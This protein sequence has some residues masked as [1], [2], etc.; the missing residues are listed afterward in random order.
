MYKRLLPIF[1]LLGLA[2]SGFLQSKAA[3]QTGKTIQLED[4]NSSFFWD[5]EELSF[6]DDWL[7]DEIDSLFSQK[8]F[9]GF[10]DLTQPESTLS[11]FNLIN[12]RQSSANQAT[13][14]FLGFS[15]R[16]QVDITTSLIGGIEGS[17]RSWLTERYTL[18]NHASEAEDLAFFYYQ[19]YDMG[20]ASSFNNDST[21]VDGNRVIQ[22]DGDQSNMTECGDSLS[23]FPQC[24][25]TD[26][27]VIVKSDQ[28][29]DSFEVDTYPQLLAKFFNESST[30]LDSEKD[31]LFDGDGTVAL[32]FNRR[33]DQ[34]ESMAFNFTK[35]LKVTSTPPSQGVPEPAV[36]LA[37]LIVGGYFWKTRH[38][39]SS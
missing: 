11:D 35:S 39:R 3:A 16:L 4:G 34:N 31:S 17:G 22:F 8:L 7:I 5:F 14:S 1:A 15:N 30:N 21:L 32:Q 33:L 29:P 38:Q 6:E 12:I 24:S 18:T 28:T 20:G 36:G 23:T 37:V 26:N 9:F 25:T 2:A 13:A 10:G 19:D 27:Y